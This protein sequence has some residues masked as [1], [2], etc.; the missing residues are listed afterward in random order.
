MDYSF[1]AWYFSVPCDSGAGV[2]NPA[3]GYRKSTV[4][5]LVLMSGLVQHPSVD[6][7]SDRTPSG[8][9]SRPRRVTGAVRLVA[10]SGREAR[11]SPGTPQ[12]NTKQIETLN[13]SSLLDPESLLRRHL[14]NCS[15]ITYLQLVPDTYDKYVGNFLRK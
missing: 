9:G 3:H 6:A 14:P 8:H 11:Q 2:S 1:P 5:P 4:V 12:G 7:G 10:P 13:E 15:T